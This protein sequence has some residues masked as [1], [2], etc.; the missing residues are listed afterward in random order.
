MELPRDRYRKAA[1]D[2]LTIKETAQKYGVS[3]QAVWLC[4]KNNGIVFHDAKK[5]PD[6]EEIIEM[7]EGGLT[8][9]EIAKKKGES[10][11]T[12]QSFFASKGIKAKPK[13]RKY[14]GLYPDPKDKRRIHPEEIRARFAYCPKTGVVRDKNKGFKPTGYVDAAGY[15]SIYYNRLNL[16]AHRIAWVLHYGG[17]P[18]NVI[19]HINGIKTDN[20]IENLRDVTQAENAKFARQSQMARAGKA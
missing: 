15:I 16:K 13:Q 12:I 17:W 2:G 7:F 1:A 11:S 8:F 9:S 4:A 5:R 3:P 14:K 6:A 19:D 20:R 18:D 10:Y